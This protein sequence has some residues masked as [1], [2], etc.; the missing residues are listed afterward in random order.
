MTVQ[1]TDR[2]ANDP[3]SWQWDFDND[4]TIDSIA[5]NPS[6]EFAEPGE[7]TV[8]LTAANAHGEDSMTQTSYIEVREALR[9][10]TV[11]SSCDGTGTVE[12]DPVGIDCGAD[13][14]E[15]F[16][17]GI[18][19][20]LSAEASPGSEFCG[21]KGGWCS[22]TGDCVTTMDIDK[23]VGACFELLP[24]EILYVVDPDA[25]CGDF[26]PCYHNIQDAIDNAIVG[27]HIRVAHGTYP[28]NIAI[29]NRVKLDCGWNTDFTA[30]NA[31]AIELTGP[32]D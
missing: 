6:F 8:T 10:L 30:R 3:T 4:S 1:F 11:Y 28:E 23:T 21:W 7:Y 14:S 5:Q 2:S 26:D 16:P 20:T 25:N 29:D 27:A 31:G 9:T 18:E 22:G 32:R 12:S 24:T 13:C 15:N 19:V 17:A